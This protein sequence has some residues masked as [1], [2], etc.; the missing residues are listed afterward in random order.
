MFLV[1]QGL[2]MWG[3]WTADD[4]PTFLTSRSQEAWNW[5]REGSLVSCSVYS[6]L[7]ALFTEAVRGKPFLACHLSLNYSN[8]CYAGSWLYSH[9]SPTNIKCELVLKY[10]LDKIFVS[11]F[12]DHVCLCLCVYAPYACTTCG[13]QKKGLNFQELIV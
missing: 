11:P 5:E 3:I 4:I 6:K 9:S 10:F 7:E 2:D 13:G 8:H 1:F 12:F